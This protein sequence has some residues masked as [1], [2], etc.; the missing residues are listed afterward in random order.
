M[1][2]QLLSFSL[3]LALIKGNL[4]GNLQDNLSHD[5]TQ[6]SI[7]T[8][9]LSL[10]THRSL[11][12]LT[13]TDSVSISGIRQ[14]ISFSYDNENGNIFIL[15]KMGIVRL[16]KDWVCSTPPAILDISRNVA[17]YG[18]HGATSILYDNSFIYIR[19]NRNNLCT[20][21]FY[22]LSIQKKLIDSH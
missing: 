6:V 1:F 14:P 10:V 16:C 7:S 9:G 12:S 3:T 4:Q 17:S 11:A 5:V 18:D 13:I 15:Q 20:I 19:C 21:I 22:L 2:L 8:E